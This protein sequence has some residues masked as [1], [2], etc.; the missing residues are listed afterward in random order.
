MCDIP[1]LRRRYGASDT[2]PQHPRSAPGQHPRSAPGQEAEAQHQ[3]PGG[4]G[5]AP[6]YRRIRSPSVSAAAWGCVGGESQHHA[7]QHQPC[8]TPSTPQPQQQQPWRACLSRTAAATPSRGGCAADGWRQP[9]RMHVC[10]VQQQCLHSTQQQQQ[11]HTPHPP[12]TLLPAH[13][14]SHSYYAVLNVARDASQEDI[15]R[16][17]K[18]LAQVFHP[19]ACCCGCCCR[20]CAGVCSLQHVAEPAGCS[21]QPSPLHPTPA[22]TH[23]YRQAPGRRAAWQRTGGVLKAAGG[24]RG[25]VERATSNGNGSPALAAV[26][27]QCNGGCTTDDALTTNAHQHAALAPCKCMTAFP[28]HIHRCFQTPPSVMCMTCMERR[29]LAQVG[30]CSCQQGAVPPHPSSRE[31]QQQQHMCSCDRLG[32]LLAPRLQCHG[33]PQPRHAPEEHR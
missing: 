26:C 15:K 25:V 12:R 32:V 27:V 24:V 17:Y 1:D 3:G 9:T 23:L 8:H 5:P 6:Q 28:T 33:R 22:H 16:A 10:S 7:L 13:S 4:R 29:A 30:G 18:G 21:V 14:P 19:G 11:P 31:Q 20:C 2:S